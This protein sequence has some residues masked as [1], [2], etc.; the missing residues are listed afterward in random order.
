MWQQK[1]T[2]ELDSTDEHTAVLSSVRMLIVE[3]DRQVGQALEDYFVY[4][5][6]LITRA[7]DGEQALEL[8][9]K[10]PAFD[11]VLLDVSLPKKSGFEVLKESQE[12]GVTSPIL[13]VTARGGREHI[14]RGFGLGAQ[15][16]VLKPFDVDDLMERVVTILSGGASNET[17][18]SP[19]QIG[20]VMIDFD[21]EAALIG[22]KKIDFSELEFALLRTLVRNRGLVVT[23]Q[24]LIREAWGID[25]DNVA[26]SIST[27]VVAETVD[28][29]IEKIRQY[30]E[31]SPGNDG[32]IETVYGLGYRLLGS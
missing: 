29:H 19:C 10:K 16:Y 28:V 31:R 22:D 1:E 17:L 23:R 5:G 25:S 30:L 27:D 24:R 12:C 15:D 7:E 18:E 21:A 3:D 20:Q 13:M 6:A 9:K 2:S 11:M 14:L 26:F 4:Y 8:M 32:Y